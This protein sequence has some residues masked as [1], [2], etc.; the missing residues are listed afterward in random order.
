M[1]AI[2]LSARDT[3]AIRRCLVETRYSDT[4]TAA[5]HEP[6]DHDLLSPERVHCCVIGGVK[7][8][9]HERNATYAKLV[10]SVSA[11]LQDLESRVAA[12]DE[13]LRIVEI[14]NRQGSDLADLLDEGVDGYRADWPD[15][16]RAAVARWRG[17]TTPDTTT[18]KE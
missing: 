12:N 4:I 6:W 13:A 9:W 16:A 11:R 17:I 3:A 10:E 15:R 1:V 5:C 8:Q 18:D 14:L 2:E 7:F